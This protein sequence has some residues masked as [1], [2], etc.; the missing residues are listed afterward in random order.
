M[1]VIMAFV[2]A[3]VVATPG[4]ET[5]VQ[6]GLQI[7]R[8]VLIEWEVDPQQEGKAQI[9]ECAKGIADDEDD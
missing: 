9:I 6:G 5:P 8:S 7:R 2:T 1:E 3:D 4:E